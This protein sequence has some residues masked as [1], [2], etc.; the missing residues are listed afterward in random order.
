LTIFRT[1]LIFNMRIFLFILL[2]PVLYSCDTLQDVNEIKGPCT[3]VLVDGSTVVSNGNIE[4]MDK[5]GAITYRDDAGKIW[6][7]FKDDYQSYTCN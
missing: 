1:D 4:I 7:L 6:S 5:T 3:I 2:L